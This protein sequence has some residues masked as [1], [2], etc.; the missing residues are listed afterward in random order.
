MLKRYDCVISLGALCIASRTLRNCHIQKESMPFDW[1]MAQEPV[2]E[3][4]GDLKGRV[5]LILNRFEN[6]FNLSDFSI[7]DT[8][9]SNSNHLQVV[10][11]KT[12][13]V[14]LHDFTYSDSIESSYKEAKEKYDRR[15][16]RFYD[17]I[18]S[19]NKILFLYITLNNSISNNDFLTEVKRIR[20]Y[21]NDTVC[22]FL[23][24]DNDYKMSE[25]LIKQEEVFD[26]VYRVTMNVVKAP[27]GANPI[28]GNQPLLYQFL[29]NF[30]YSQ[31][32]EEFF[33]SEERLNNDV[34]DCQYQNM[35]AFHC[36]S[37]EH[38]KALYEHGNTKSAYIQKKEEIDNS[39][40]CNK[41]KN[42]NLRPSFQKLRLFLA[43]FF[44]IITAIIMYLYYGQKAVELT[45]KSE[46]TTDTVYKVFYTESA[47]ERFS[48]TKKVI[49][50]VS[51]G[52]ANCKFLIPVNKIERLR[53]NIGSG[54]GTAKLSN[55]VLS[56]KGKISISSL[57]S[58]TPYN[59]ESIRSS[60]NGVYSVAYNHAF[61]VLDYSKPLSLQ[62][63]KKIVDWFA[64]V[65]S[66]IGIFYLF[67]VLT[68]SRPKD[69]SS[70]ASTF[71][72]KL[73]NIEFLRIYFTFFVLAVH[74]FTLLFGI[75]TS[76][77]IGV[78]F[79]FILSGYLLA[80]NYRSDRSIV[81]FAV[82]RWIRFV[83]LVVFGGLISYGIKWK[84]LYGFSM[85]YS[86]GLGLNGVGNGPAWYIGVLFWASLFYL[87]LLK[88]LKQ[89]TRN[90]LISIIVSSLM[91]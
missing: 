76:G 66:S 90:F 75:W 58:L 82:D 81:R 22:D 80:L 54:K 57:N 1:V 50:K 42:N 59:I 4:R 37:K 36:S 15:V 23:Y 34:T 55:I 47:T 8:K 77:T 88:S 74:F 83:P 73:A 29:K 20:G 63:T 7:L 86:V 64:V 11:N 87:A 69:T 28:W 84:A 60:E 38:M 67:Y 71:K 16:N 48:T 91:R 79:F 3:G 49:K 10:N 14:Y 40:S 61:P 70:K 39:I 31:Y 89:E 35:I 62:G 30:C 19:S 68:E 21:C 26:G 2:Q 56:G 25:R 5:D 43:L 85:L 18:E 41:S 9:P 27:E 17:T 32:T 46:S 44:A 12:G 6:Y 65:L 53:I 13:L 72:P 52:T 24:I 51:S 45:F 33:A 78:E